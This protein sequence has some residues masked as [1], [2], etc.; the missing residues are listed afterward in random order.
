MGGSFLH[1]FSLLA[2]GFNQTNVARE[3]AINQG[4]RSQMFAKG[5]LMP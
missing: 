3:S 1:M 2:I 4:S 5:H